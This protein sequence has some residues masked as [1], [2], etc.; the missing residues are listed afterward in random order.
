[1]YFVKFRTVKGLWGFGVQKNEG[2]IG[3]TV[4]K[5]VFGFLWR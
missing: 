2:E 1:M 4:A 5:W 3:V